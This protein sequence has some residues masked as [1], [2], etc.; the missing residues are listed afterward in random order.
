MG[1]SICLN[2][3]G[4]RGL[5]N[6]AMMG[7]TTTMETFD[8]LDPAFLDKFVGDDNKEEIQYF[9][10]S[11]NDED[12]DAVV[13]KKRKKKKSPTTTTMSKDEGEGAEDFEDG[14]TFDA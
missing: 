12:E 11:S 4:H 14:F 13:P 5:E 7:S 3:L 8:P 1:V 10:S 2:H 6:R 9:S